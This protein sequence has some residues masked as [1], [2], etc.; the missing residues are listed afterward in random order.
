MQHCEVCNIKV[1]NPVRK[2]EIYFENG[3]RTTFMP[4]SE[5]MCDDCIAEHMAATMRPESVIDKAF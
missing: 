4:N 5:K 1:N 3:S 2:V